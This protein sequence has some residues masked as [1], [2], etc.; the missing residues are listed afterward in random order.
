M[1][2][3]VGDWVEAALQASG[4]SAHLPAPVFARLRSA[5]AARGASSDP[6][7]LS[8]LRNECPQCH[9]P[10]TVSRLAN[11]RHARAACV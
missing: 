11:R 2:A 4:A 3:H 9:A 7:A 6:P 5:L 1:A 10:L 8:S